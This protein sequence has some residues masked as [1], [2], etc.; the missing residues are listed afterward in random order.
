MVPLDQKAPLVTLAPWALRAPT[1]L[2]ASPESRAL[3]ALVV[4][5]ALQERR[6][7]RAKK[8]SRAPRASVD[9]LAALEEMDWRALPVIRAHPV[10]QAPT[11]LPASA[12]PLAEKALLATL[13][14]WVTL[15]KLAAMEPLALPALQA[16]RAPQGL[17]VTKCMC[18]SRP[19]LPFLTSL[20]FFQAN[21]VPGVMTAR[22]AVTAHL[23]DVAQQEK[24]AFQ[25]LAVPWVRSARQVKTVECMARRALLAP[26]DTIDAFQ[27][28]YMFL[29][30]DSVDETRA[31]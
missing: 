11:A 23:A 4:C 17:Q 26:Q 15:V 9:V 27:I 21:P 16:C 3:L 14:P 10:L 25:V 29:Y 18:F 1:A 8:V 19:L 7:C 13:A 22:T 12:V 28:K 30:G 5:R 6:V 31:R 2:K 20:F 24:W